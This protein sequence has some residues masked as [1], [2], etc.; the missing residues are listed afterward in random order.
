MGYLA[1]AKRKFLAANE[2][3]ARIRA[4]E[5]KK[6]IESGKHDTSGGKLDY[7]FGN[8]DG[9]Q[10]CAVGIEVYG[11]CPNCNIFYTREPTEAERETK[12]YKEMLAEVRREP[13]RIQRLMNTP[14]S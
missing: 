5:L 8:L 12:E 4:E 11:D 3:R 2:E 13:D 6:C 14:L 9:V 7:I 1:E 10:H